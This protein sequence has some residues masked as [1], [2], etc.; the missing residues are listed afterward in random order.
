M[1]ENCSDERFV[2][3]KNALLMLLLSHHTPL[4]RPNKRHQAAA[5]NVGRNK[6]N[7]SSDSVI[8]LSSSGSLTN[9][10]HISACN[11]SALH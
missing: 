6:I 4:I 9:D 10:Y 11:Q 1:S 7:A 5:S 8:K 2:F 3:L